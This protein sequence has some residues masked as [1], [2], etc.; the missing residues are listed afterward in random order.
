MVRAS[1]DMFIPYFVLLFHLL[2]RLEIDFL[3]TQEIDAVYFSC[4]Q[5]SYKQQ[6]LSGFQW[7]IQTL[8]IEKCHSELGKGHV[9]HTKNIL[10]IFLKFMTHSCFICTVYFI[11][12]HSSI[13]HLIFQFFTT[14]WKIVIIRSSQNRPENLW[15]H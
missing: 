8:F 7:I 10:I 6:R 13:Q 9:R 11:F 1:K 4:C 15:S 5:Y 2:F 14:E 12:P 3:T